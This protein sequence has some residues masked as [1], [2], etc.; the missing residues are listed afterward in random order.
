MTGSGSGE[1]GETSAPAVG[2]AVP[3]AV[4]RSWDEAEAGLF[5]L[6]MARPDLYQQAIGLIQRLAGRL[7]ETCPD[8]P[9][10]L[11][12]HEQGAHLAADGPAAAELAGWAAA[13][14]RPEQVA[15][16]ACAMRYRE[17]VALLAARNRLAAL[18]RAREEGKS[19]AVIEESGSPQRAPYIPYQRIEADVTTG[20]AVIVS[21]EPDETLSRAVHRLDRAQLDLASGGL[22]AGGQIGRYPDE[23]ALTTALQQVRT[24]AGGAS[25][26]ARP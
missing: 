21:I 6:V 8:V 14:I 3:P 18:A 15:A 19:W 13:G 4:L 22:Q 7:R 11:A 25:P 9:A 16:A 26:P 24:D 10:L 12:A 23:D 2:T 1:G 20:R 17:L 5:P